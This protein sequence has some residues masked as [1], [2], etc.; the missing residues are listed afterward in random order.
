MKH[1]NAMKKR[2]L[3]AGLLLLACLALSACYMEPDRIVDNNNGLNVG[4]GGQG[5]DTVIT[6]TPTVTV[7]PTPAPTS[8]VVDWSSWDF[9]SDTA[10]NPPSNVSPTMGT[11]GGIDPVVPTSAPQIARLPRGPRPPPP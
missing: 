7:T 1:P 8:N 6:P 3:L 10:T 9:G 4:D 5:F 2:A 11:Q